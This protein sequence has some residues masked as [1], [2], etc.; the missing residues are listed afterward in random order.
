VNEKGGINTQAGTTL[1]KEKAFAGR[2][3]KDGFTN[4]S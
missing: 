1:R 3:E 2:K 4:S